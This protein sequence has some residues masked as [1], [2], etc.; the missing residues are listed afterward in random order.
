MWRHLKNL[1]WCAENQIKINSKKKMFCIGELRQK[2]FAFDKVK[3]M[4]FKPRSLN[5]KFYIKISP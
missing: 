2:L 3:K 1:K 4:Y 5:L